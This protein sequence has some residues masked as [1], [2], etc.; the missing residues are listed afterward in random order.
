MPGFRSVLEMPH[1]HSPWLNFLLKQGK[2][3]KGNIGLFPPSYTAPAPLV[4]ATAPDS[5]RVQNVK[6]ALF[7]L[8]E[9]SKPNL[10][11]ETMVA[12]LA[13]LHTVLL[14]PPKHQYPAS[15]SYQSTAH[16]GLMVNSLTLDLM[17]KLLHLP[18]YSITASEMS[19]SDTELLL[20]FI[21]HVCIHFCISLYV[22]FFL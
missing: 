15:D 18:E 12:L 7:P 13:A 19:T 11:S 14:V 1:T 8:D 6:S 2:N 20:D 21:L 22:I 9:E 16:G 5:L 17:S 10:A 3:L 4:P